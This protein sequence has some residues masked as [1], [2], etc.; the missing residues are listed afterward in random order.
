MFSVFEKL[1][2]SKCKGP[3]GFVISK[4]AILKSDF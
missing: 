2:G 3:F 1:F 4:I